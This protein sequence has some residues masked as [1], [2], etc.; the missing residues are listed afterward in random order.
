MQ[1]EV[2]PEAMSGAFA[3]V[4]PL[5]ARSGEPLSPAARQAFIDAAPP[6]LREVIAGK[7]ATITF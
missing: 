7:I 1:A 3:A 4:Y 5:G 6:E 2:S